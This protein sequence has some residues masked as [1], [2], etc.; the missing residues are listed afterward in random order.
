MKTLIIPGL[1]GSPE[2]HWQ[3]WWASKDPSALVVDQSD[4]STP[5]PEAWEAEV[6]GAILR[7]PGSVLVGHSLGSVLIARLLTKWPQLQVRAAILVAPAE[8]S[9]SV[10]IARFG[11]VPQRPLGVPAMVVASRNDP[12]MS[13]ARARDL[14]QGWGAGII[15]MGHVGHINVTSGFGPWPGVIG[16]RETLLD[17]V[18]T[19]RILQPMERRA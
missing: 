6:A 19:S 11:P 13:F 17:P 1:D 2:P 15:D 4:W 10:R 16:M 8:P 3:H 18:P 12:W 5:T 9:R 14:A 7:H